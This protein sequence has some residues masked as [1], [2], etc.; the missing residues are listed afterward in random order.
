MR[1]VTGSRSPKRRGWLGAGDPL[2][3]QKEIS[4]LSFLSASYIEGRKRKNLR[5]AIA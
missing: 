5:L 4:T 1:S 3:E 2:G